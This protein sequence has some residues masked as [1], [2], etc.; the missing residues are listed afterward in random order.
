[1]HCQGSPLR[2]AGEQLYCF[3]PARCGKKNYIVVQYVICFTF[4][5]NG[6]IEMAAKE[7]AANQSLGEAKIKVVRK[8]GKKGPVEVPWF[9]EKVATAPV[10]AINPVAGKGDN[11]DQLEGTVR[12][13]N[14]RHHCLLS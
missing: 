9:V 4:L 2:L 6:I 7:A 11:Y 1:M 14:E 12:V 3:N 8:N 10:Q 5:G 13:I